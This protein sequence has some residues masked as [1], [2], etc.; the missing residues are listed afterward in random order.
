MARDRIDEAR[1]V[2]HPSAAI[3]APHVSWMALA[4]P[5]TTDVWRSNRDKA[6][7]T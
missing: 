1:E 3:I 2:A 6:V 5:L 7:V 4:N